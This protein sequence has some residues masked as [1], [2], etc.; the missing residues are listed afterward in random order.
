MAEWIAEE[1]VPVEDRDAAPGAPIRLAASGCTAC[2][3]SSFPAT[4]ACTWCGAPG[5]DPVPLSRGTAV[6]ATAVLHRTPG[7]IVR[8][9]FVVALARFGRAGLDVLGRVPGRTDP[10]AVP[11]GTPLRVVAESLPD[12]RMHYAFAVARD[13]GRD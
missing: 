1:L 13:G 8:V 10:A 2:G 5:S 11:P 7:A 9:P 12:G 4:G 3:R 6:A